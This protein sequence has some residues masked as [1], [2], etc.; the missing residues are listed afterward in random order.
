MLCERKSFSVYFFAKKTFP[1]FMDM[2][3][4]KWSSCYFNHVDHKTRK[5]YK[6]IYSSCLG[7]T[8]GAGTQKTQQHQEQTLRKH[9][10]KKHK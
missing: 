9:K 1:V 2:S 3:G 5:L 7:R 8:R 6:A 10:H 4:T